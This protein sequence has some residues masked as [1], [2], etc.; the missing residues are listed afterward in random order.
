MKQLERRSLKKIRASTEFKPVT[1]TISVRCFTN[2]AMKPHIGERPF[3]LH[4]PL[5]VAILDSRSAF[6]ERLTQMHCFSKLPYNSWNNVAFKGHVIWNCCWHYSKKLMQISCHLPEP[7][8]IGST[9]SFLKLLII[10]AL[11]PPSLARNPWIN[12]HSTFFIFWTFNLN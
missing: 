5:L 9:R 11:K 10:A 4:S 1:S 3:L 2:W 7:P 12:K 6:S 8:P